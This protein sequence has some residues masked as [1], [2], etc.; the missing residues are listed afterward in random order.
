MCV[1]RLCFSYSTFQMPRHDDI[2]AIYELDGGSYNQRLA[3]TFNS[4]VPG[5][6]D[7]TWNDLAVNWRESVKR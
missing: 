2:V 3:S 4:L 7:W 1:Q 5:R 6:L